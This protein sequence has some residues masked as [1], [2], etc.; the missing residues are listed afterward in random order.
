MDDKIQI[1]L[2]RSKI[3]KQVLEKLAEKPQIATFLAKELEKHRET[4]S[5]IFKDLE[6]QGLAKCKNPEDASFRYYEIT[7]KGKNNI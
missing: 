2:A 5:R 3:R 1:F 6:E 4:I 7:E